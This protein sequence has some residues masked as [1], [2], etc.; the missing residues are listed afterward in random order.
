MRTNG[1]VKLLRNKRQ[2]K[3]KLKNKHKRIVNNSKY[4]LSNIINNLKTKMIR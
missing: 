2:E 3:D 1:K 4:L